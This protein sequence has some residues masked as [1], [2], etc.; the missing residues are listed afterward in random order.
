M[1]D[2]NNTH[3][4]TTKSCI[5]YIQARL[6]KDNIELIYNNKITKF[7]SFISQTYVNITK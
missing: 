4:Y 3:K 1:K 7:T 2:P 5:K 6:T